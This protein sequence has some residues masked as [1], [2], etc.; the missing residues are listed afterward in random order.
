MYIL[1]VHPTGTSYPVLTLILY[2]DQAIVDISDQT[3]S[4]LLAVKTRPVPVVASIFSSKIHC[5]RG[6][7]VKWIFLKTLP[8]LGWGGVLIP[9]SCRE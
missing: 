9:T 1:S 8:E 3:S 7:K 5:K 2:M 4:V 6:L